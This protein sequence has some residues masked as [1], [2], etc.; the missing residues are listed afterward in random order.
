MFAIVLV[1]AASSHAVAQERSSL[2]GNWSFVTDPSGKLD[3]ADLSTASG[4]RTAQVPGSWQSEFADLRDY[5]GVAW[6]W[7]TFSA[8][9][10]AAGHVLLVRFGAVDYK[11]TVY[12]NGQKAGEHEGGYLPFEIDIT[13]FLRAGENELAVRVVDPGAKPAE[14]EGIRYAEIPHGKQDWYVQTS[15][16]WQSV[17]LEDR[18]KTRIGAMHIR[19]GADGRFTIDLEI[20]NSPG[21]SEAAGTSSSR[22][23]ASSSPSSATYAGAEIRDASGKTVWKQSLNLASGQAHSSF[24]GTLAKPQLWS[25]GTPYLYTVQAWIYSGDSITSPFG[26]RTFDTRGG[27]FY[28]N[29]QPIYLRG[30]LDQDFYP[31]T[32]YTPPSLDFVRQEMMAAKAVGLNLLRCHIKVPDPRYLDAADSAGILVWYEIPNWDKLTGDSGRRGLKT[33]QGMATRDWNHP[34][35]VAVSLINESWGADLKQAPQ[36]DWLK[37][38]STQAHELVPGW[39]V[40]DNSACCDNFHMASDIADFHDYASI[41]DAASDFDR[42]V[43]DLASRPAWLWSPYND[44]QVNAAAPLMLSEFGNWGL[45]H[46]PDPPP[47]WFDR[48]FGGREITRPAGFADRYTSYYSTLF[49]GLASLADATEEH[50]Y[51]SLKYEIESLR[52]HPEIQGYVITEFTDI[53]WESNGLF[54]MWRH[55]KVS[56]SKLGPLQADDLIIARIPK[57]NFVS[58]EHVH[59]DV[60]VSHYSTASL[61]GGS[62]LWS[63]AGFDQTYVKPLHAIEPG[64]AAPAGAIDFTAPPVSSPQRRILSFRVEAGGK[65]LSENSLEMYFYPPRKEELPPA[66]SFVDPAGRLRRLSDEM[67]AHGYLAPSGKEALPVVIASTLNDQV[68]AVLENG[69][70][71]ILIASDNQSLSPGIEITPRAQSDLD[72]NW[73]SNFLWVRKDHPIFHGTGFSTLPGFEAQAV[74]P[75][76]VIQG[77]PPSAFPDVLAGM[78]YGWLHLNAGVLVQARAGKGKLLVTTFGL[79][80]AYGTDP[81]ATALLDDIVQYVVGDFAPKFE[82]PLTP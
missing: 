39:L 33:L 43:T 38:F 6:Y 41:P 68:Q 27:R 31:D 18:P 50:Q 44:S 20:I 4:A 25:P 79:G 45:P 1:A 47:W 34:S 54:D 78:F 59:A 15:G 19:A 63:L 21:A 23:G 9:A 57:R 77:L 69:G 81:Y 22:V 72:G 36:R 58:G 11:A 35:V 32:V 55:P 56:A 60:Y 8:P 14:V 42:F 28:L 3:V 61:A 7:R 30:A 37:Q 17:E 76:A 46:V 64:S 80:E 65:P 52:S 29:G 51:E 71:V 75:P 10:P 67:R 82:V 62:I 5:A 53:N 24:S 74:N 13:P 66:V 12:V 40:D 2:D 73:I 16:P 48:D 70:R 26:F 49:P